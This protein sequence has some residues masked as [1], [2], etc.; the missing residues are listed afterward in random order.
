MKTVLENKGYT[1]VTA[2]EW[3]YEN[4]PARTKV[5]SQHW[6]EGF[7]FPLPGERNPDRY[8]ILQ[9]GYYEPDTP[10]KMSGIGGG[11]AAGG[12]RGPGLRGCSGVYGWPE[13]NQ[14]VTLGASRRCRKCHGLPILD[15]Q[16]D[17]GSNPT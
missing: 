1:V 12:R 5:A 6:D 15:D 4:V 11:R 17:G 7:P 16:R 9:L 13:Y 8:Q 10:D 14:E 3:F 2:S